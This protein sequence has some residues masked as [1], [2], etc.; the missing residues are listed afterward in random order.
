M[1]EIGGAEGATAWLTNAQAM[2][3]DFQLII[4]GATFLFLVTTLFILNRAV[5]EMGKARNMREQ[6]EQTFS[7]LTGVL[8]SLEGRDSPF[9]EQRNARRVS[10]SGPTRKAQSA[11]SSVV[12]TRPTNTRST[13]RG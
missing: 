7:K 3:L 4:L 8:K 13:N 1:S 5:D 12:A 6:T 11:Q 2:Y 9:A 10:M